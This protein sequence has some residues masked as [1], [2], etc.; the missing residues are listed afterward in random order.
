MLGKNRKN[1]EWS[2]M[3]VQDRL[4]LMAAYKRYKCLFVSP[5]ANKSTIHDF[6][7]WLL[8]RGIHQEKAEQEMLL[9]H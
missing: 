6:R 4:Y 7:H 8:K 3:A 1:M 2:Q 9:N 5:D